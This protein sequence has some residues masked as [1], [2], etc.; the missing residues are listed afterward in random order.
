MV[1]TEGIAMMKLIRVKCRHPSDAQDD[2]PYVGV[3]FATHKGHAE[4]LCRD[5]FADRGFTSFEAEEPIDGPFENVQPQV[6][7]Y[8]GRRL[9]AAPIH[10]LCRAAMET[11]F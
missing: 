4:Q 1:R 6:I 10:T 9:T 5:A 7:V 2:D 3:T 11:S 8:E